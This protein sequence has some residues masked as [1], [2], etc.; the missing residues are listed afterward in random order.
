MTGIRSNV[1][2]I[3][4]ESE[5]EVNSMEEKKSPI[6]MTSD[7]FILDPLFLFHLQCLCLGITLVSH[8]N[9]IVIS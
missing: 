5:A 3:A 9:S 7:F 4:N 1:I 8:L 2:F 6:Y